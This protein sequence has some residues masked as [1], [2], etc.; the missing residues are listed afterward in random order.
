MAKI[1]HFSGR[2]CAG[3]PLKGQDVLVEIFG[4]IY[5]MRNFAQT[6]RSIG[7]SVLQRADT[8]TFS[9]QVPFVESGF[10]ANVSVSSRNIIGAR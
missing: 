3:T 7:W 5:V 8:E 1:L 6:F 2:N 9:E 10:V 4:A